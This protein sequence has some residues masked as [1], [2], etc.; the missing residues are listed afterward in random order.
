MNKD[1]EKIFALSHDAVVVAE[2]GCISYSNAAA[3]ELFGA[4]L[5]GLSSGEALPSHILESGA[6]EFVSSACVRGTM[7][8]ASCL[9]QGDRLTVIFSD[10]AAVGDDR[11]ILSDRL[12]STMLSSLFNV[13]LSIDLV[14]ARLPDSCRDEKS[15][16]YLSILHHNYYTMKRVVSNLSTA[17][18]LKNGTFQIFPRRT[19]LAGLCSDL[20]STVS[21][22][23]GKNVKLSFHTDYG[24]L[25]TN[26]D[27]DSVERVILNLISNSYRAVPEGGRIDLR[28]YTRSSRA[29]I[30]VSDNGSGIPPEVM[31][32]VFSPREP[33]ALPSDP[34]VSGCGL[35]LCVSRGIAEAHGGS[36]II[37]TRT[38]GTSVCLL[39]PLEHDGSATFASSETDFPRS[40]MELI[41]TELSG[42]LDSSYYSEKF[43]D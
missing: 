9:R 42:E 34:E 22:V 6:A 20:A 5:T 37:E 27:P 25:L 18:A 17:F 26:V 36:L 24:H 14:S 28:L 3:D 7:C 41:L 12:M 1:L 33:S 31:K 10:V 39:L 38:G 13:G 32:G 19:D 35:G 11:P 43:R 30:C 8:Q 40:G 2:G 21:L 15:R 23:L 4:S 16:R 29:V